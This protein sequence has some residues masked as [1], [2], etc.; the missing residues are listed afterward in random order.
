MWNPPV[1]QC[2]PLAHSLPC[3]AKERED[4]WSGCNKKSSNFLR[5]EETYFLRN[6]Q[7][8]K[9]YIRQVSTLMDFGLWFG[10]LVFFELCVCVFLKENPQCSIIS[11]L[12]CCQ[13]WHLRN[14]DVPGIWCVDVLL[15]LWQ[16][17]EE[18]EVQYSV[19]A[20]S[21]SKGNIV[22]SKHADFWL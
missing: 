21:W 9:K 12:L 10:V 17:L 15:W 4:S 16:C 2:E 19:D 18:V 3:G 7:N 11:P 20:R 5:I 14:Y 13:P 6:L 1:K 22:I 8:S